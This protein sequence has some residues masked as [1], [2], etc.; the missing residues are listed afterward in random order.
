MSGGIDPNKFSE[1]FSK[2]AGNSTTQL[3]IFYCPTRTVLVGWG[4][5]KKV[6][7]CLKALLRPDAVNIALL[8]EG[9]GLVEAVL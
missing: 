3:P 5:G 6:Q 1:L 4:G 8:L 7:K 2:E 9:G